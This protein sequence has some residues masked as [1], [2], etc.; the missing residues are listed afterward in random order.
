[1]VATKMQAAGLDQRRAGGD[2]GV[3]VRD[4]LDDLHGEHDVESFA[5]L[6]ER[7]RRRRAVVDRKVALLG[8]QPRDL[9]VGRRRID[10]DDLR[11]EPRHRLAQNPAA[12]ADVEQAKPG[13]RFSRLRIAREVLDD[14]I[15]DVAEPHRIELVQR[16]ELSVR[17]PPLRR[18]PL[19][20]CDLGGVDGS[21]A[22][23]AG[24]IGIVYLPIHRKICRR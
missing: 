3:D 20:F 24:C 22:V 23:A 4:M 9:D 1:M 5:R 17:A 14:D 8:V 18:H 11:A 2:E 13:E 19:E 21:I 6:A 15:A 12:A 16:P 7:L 10:A